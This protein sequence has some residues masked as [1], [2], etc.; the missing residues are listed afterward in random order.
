[1]G[2]LQG[3]V[4]SPLIANFTLDGLEERVTIRQTKGKVV[5]SPS[6]SCGESCESVF[7]HGLFVHKKCSNYAL[8]HLLFGLC[9]SV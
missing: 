6:S 8:T 9:S 7:V 1:M 5:A 4:I 2:V 3:S